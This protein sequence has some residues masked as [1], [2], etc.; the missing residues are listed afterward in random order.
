M[1]GPDFEI[2]SSPLPAPSMEPPAPERPT[3]GGAARM[4]AAALA[5]LVVISGVGVL[6]GYSALRSSSSTPPVMDSA[7]SSTPTTVILRT[8]PSSTTPPTTTPV[9]RLTKACLES[10][11][12]TGAAG[13]SSPEGFPWITFHVSPR[14]A[15]EALVRIA[16]SASEAREAFGDAGALGVRV[17]C[18]I[19]EF[20][21]ASNTPPDEVQKN[22]TQGQAAYQF[23]GDIWLYG[24]LFERRSSVDQ[25]HTIYHEYFHALQ[26]SLSRTRTGRPG[27][28][29]W[30]IEGSA[31]FFENAVTPRELENFRRVEI[32]RWDAKPALE[33]LELSGGARSTGGT[34]DA[35]T[36]GAVAAD[37]LVTRYGRERLQSE[38]WLA[39]AETDWRT[40]F[41][42]VFGVSVDTFYSEFA[43]Y[44]QTLR[45]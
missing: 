31:T 41:E 19:E 5:A 4:R 26:R 10:A 38:L 11:E 30:L 34:G 3:R 16:K 32:R 29:L 27:T 15:T 2:P 18:D 36:V 22:V 42:R 13:G 25:R 8:S 24:P 7:P 9:V 28:P 21:A 44:R 33:A 6:A 23:R 20:A 43:S 1:R 17:Y 35:Y 39:I 40:A 12:S 14:A 45:P 37:Y